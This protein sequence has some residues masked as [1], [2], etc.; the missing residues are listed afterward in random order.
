MSRTAP[1][2]RVSSPGASL[3]R[4]ARRAFFFGATAMARVF[5]VL[6]IVVAVVLG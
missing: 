5:L 4:A 6:L 3:D 1:D 2:V